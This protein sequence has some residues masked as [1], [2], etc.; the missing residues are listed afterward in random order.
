MTSY[1]NFN[2]HNCVECWWPVVVWLKFSSVCDYRIYNI[3]VMLRISLTHAHPLVDIPVK[4]D[5]SVCHLCLR[6]FNY[7]LFHAKKQFL[8]MKC[9]YYAHIYEGRSRSKV[10]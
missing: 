8:S 5:C 10:S 9:M 6:G 1:M 2:S 7:Y 3:K 4:K